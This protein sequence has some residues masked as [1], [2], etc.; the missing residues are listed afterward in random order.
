MPAVRSLA[1]WASGARSDGAEGT[2]GLPR[3][4]PSTAPGGGSD[5]AGRNISSPRGVRHWH[6]LPGEVPDAPNPSCSGGIWTM[7]S[8]MRRHCWLALKCSGLED[9]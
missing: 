3:L 5:G 4:R 6:R 2:E 1:S 9:R 7:P 8:S